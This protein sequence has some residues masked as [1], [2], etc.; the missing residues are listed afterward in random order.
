MTDETSAE[1]TP[2][3]LEPTSSGVEVF[4]SQPDPEPEK[5]E[6]PAEAEETAETAG[7]T[8]TG[9]DAPQDDDG[10]APKPKPKGVQKRIDELTSNWRSAERREQE[11][12]DEARYW[13]E[14]AMRAQQEGQQAPQPQNAQPDTTQAKPDPKSF[15]D[16]EFDPGYI[17]AVAGWQADQRIASALEKQKTELAEQRAADETQAKAKAFYDKIAD[18]G[19]A[20][21]RVLALASDPSANV[22]ATMVEVAQ[23][24]ENGIKLLAHLHDDRRELQRIAALPEHMQPYEMA[25]LETKIIA[26]Q[27]GR[28]ATKAPDPLPSASGRS[29]AMPTKDPAKMSQAEYDAWRSKEVERRQNSGW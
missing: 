1:E 20:G 5:P 6:Q 3:V 14:L 24:S 29:A 16:G 18:S 11:R 12:A 28:V 21:E 23:A 2:E 19:D 26:E 10:E 27:S 9:D 15:R 25:R 22:T 13:R 17:E 4:S 7:E 8:D